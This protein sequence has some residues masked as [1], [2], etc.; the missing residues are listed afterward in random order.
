MQRALDVA[1]RNVG[2]TGDNPSVGCVIVKDG[3]VI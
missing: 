3:V 1:A 2:A